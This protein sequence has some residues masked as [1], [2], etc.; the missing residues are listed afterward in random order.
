[1]RDKH[2]AA[3]ALEMRRQKL[4]V[5]LLPKSQNHI[6]HRETYTLNPDIRIS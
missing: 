4:H 1:M 3:L 5:Y 2:T 6:L